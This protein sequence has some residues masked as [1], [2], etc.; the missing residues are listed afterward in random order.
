M[1]FNLSLISMYPSWC[2]TPR[3]PLWN[4][5][6]LKTSFVAF[7]SLRYPLI[8]VFPLNITS[9]IVFPSFGTLSIVSGSLIS[10]SSKPTCGIPCLAFIL[11][12][13][14]GASKSHSGFQTQ[15]VPG[16]YVSVRP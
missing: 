6:S 5:P 4:Q 1:S 16:P 15:K 10:I 13:S 7:K 3:S 12:L 8:T 2:F 14:C 11:D 9:P